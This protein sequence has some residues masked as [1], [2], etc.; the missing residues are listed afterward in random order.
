MRPAP[1]AGAGARLHF[2]DFDD[3]HSLDR[4]L[5]FVV[6]GDGFNRHTAAHTH[7][8]EPAQIFCVVIIVPHAHYDGGSAGA[9]GAGWVRDPV[10]AVPHSI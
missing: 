6:H 3:A 8:V 1:A 5:A 4:F 9:G 2:G 10:G 7:V